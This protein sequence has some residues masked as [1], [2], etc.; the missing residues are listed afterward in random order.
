MEILQIVGIGV[1]A[2]L[3]LIVVKQHKPEISIQLSIAAG[4][5][6]FLLMLG[7]ISSI[8]QILEELSRRAKI[9]NLYLTTILKIVGI[10]YIGE[11]G[12]QI[13]RDAG[14]GAVGAKVEFAA[15]IL[16]LV[17]ALPI[18]AALLE[19]IIRLLP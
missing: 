9:D 11:F 6:I 8:I 10:S 13:C 17:V 3:L 14:E 12:A 15:K 5:V 4:V 18:I 2:T 16:V 7:R 1:I 19:T